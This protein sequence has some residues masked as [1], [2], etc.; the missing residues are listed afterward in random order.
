MKII[1]LK[2]GRFGTE[3]AELIRFIAQKCDPMEETVQ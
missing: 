3:T 1:I 2:F